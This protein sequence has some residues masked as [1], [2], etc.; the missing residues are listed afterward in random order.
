MPV[1][2]DIS[3]A[4]LNANDFTELD[5]LVMG[6]AYESQ[7]DLGRLGDECVYQTDLC[8]R[9]KSAGIN[10]V[11][12]EVPLTVTHRD[13]VKTYFLDFVVENAAL[14]ELKTVT[15]FSREH[16]AQILNYVFLAGLSRGKL[17]NFR[18]QKVE[19]KLLVTPFT[20]ETR[21]KIQVCASKWREL[22]PECGVLRTTLMNLLMDWG[23]CLETRLYEE[24]LIHFL[25]GKDQ[26]L[27]R[28]EIRRGDIQLGLQCFTVHAPELA[29]YLT[30][31]PETTDSWKVHLNRLIAHTPLRAIQWINLSH[32]KI[33]FET[34]SAKNP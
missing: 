19:G 29:F 9:L 12:T 8:H 17:L 5:Y 18:S 33:R 27:Q 23:A 26:V 16:D 10:R 6:S 3:F 21:R 13:F 34:V 28:L 20:L 15:T 1:H 11:N 31:M 14:Y 24:G 22:S 30:G 25:G 7:N 4:P 2:C 32:N